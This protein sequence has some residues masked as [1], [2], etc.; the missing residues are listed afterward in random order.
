MLLGG[1]ERCVARTAF[2]RPCFVAL[3]RRVG[4]HRIGWMGAAPAAAAW[5]GWALL[6]PSIPS[7]GVDGRSLS[8]T[9][10]GPDNAASAAGVY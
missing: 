9:L 1:D 2:S 6:L 3:R 8:R 5:G 7:R 4:E 10:S